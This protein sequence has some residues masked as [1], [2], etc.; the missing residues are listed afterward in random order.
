VGL[1][2]EIAISTIPEPNLPLSQADTER[3]YLSVFVSIPA[4][5]VAGA[6]TMIFCPYQG[7]AIPDIEG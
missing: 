7:Y 1:C 4:V 5:P 3:K 6:G 2:P